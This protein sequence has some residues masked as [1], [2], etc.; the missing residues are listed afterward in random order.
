M[1]CEYTDISLSN[2]SPSSQFL[3]KHLFIQLVNCLQQLTNECR[4]VPLTFKVLNTLLKLR[5]RNNLLN[6]KLLKQTVNHC[7]NNLPCETSVYDY[8]IDHKLVD[9]RSLYFTRASQ[10][11]NDDFIFLYFENPTANAYLHSLVA[12]NILPS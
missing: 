8:S 4:S 6:S 10:S 9:T 1:F 12:N 11:I 7:I 2:P 5:N 3:S